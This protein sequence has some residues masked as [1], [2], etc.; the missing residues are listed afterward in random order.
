M[1]SPG[2]AGVE[3]F[4]TTSRT[5]SCICS[6]LS[7][8]ECRAA[9]G[10]AFEA[11]ARIERKLTVTKGLGELAVVGEGLNDTR[12]RTCGSFLFSVVNDGQFVHVS[13]DALNTDAPPDTPPIR[14]LQGGLVRDH[15]RPQFDEHAT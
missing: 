8:L 5:S 3:R 4:V 13:L 9:T 6:E 7:L 12:C 1:C 2:S 10:S 11:F 15:R 14:R